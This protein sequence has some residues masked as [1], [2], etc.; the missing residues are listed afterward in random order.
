MSKQVSKG[1]LAVI[2]VIMVALL[3]SLGNSV[4]KF[5][6]NKIDGKFNLLISNEN[7]DLESVIK[8]YFNKKKIPVKITYA[9]TL[10]MMNKINSGEKYDAIW[11]SNSIW[12]YM[13]DN[14][15]VVK[16]SKSTSINPI[17]FGIKK[18]LAQKLNF[19]GRDVYTKDILDKIVAKELNFVM[20]SATRTNTGASAYLG[21][22]ATLAGNPEVLTIDN[23]KDENLKEDIVKFLSGVERTSGSEEF[24]DSLLLDGKYDA[25]VSYESS[26]I[27]LNKKLVGEGKEPFY[28]IYPVDG[29][30]ISDSPLAYI[31][32]GNNKKD[33]FD[34]FQNF[35]LSAEFQKELENS[36]R[37]VW[38]GGVSNNSDNSIFN[39]DWG[40]DTTKYIMP[41]KYPS[42]SVI[43]EA[44]ALYQSEFR[45]PT[46]IVF[47][48]DYSGSMY[49]DGNEQLIDAMKYILNFDTASLNMLQFSY[50]D[51]ISIIPFATNVLG[52][53]TTNDGTIVSELLE[54]IETTDTMG[55]TNIYGSLKKALSILNDEDTSNY[56]LSIV[57]M[58]DG[59]GNIDTFN[60]FKNYYNS[61]NKDIPIYGILFGDADASQLNEISNYTGGKVFDGRTNLLEAFKEV[62][63][64][65]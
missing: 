64:Y 12:L 1:L 43:K 7:V 18:S 50:K 29:V 11:A 58:T 60:S 19:I 9:G 57:L 40:I 28:L 5:I 36:G 15:S 30:T 45:K 47:C 39:K 17:V 6:E 22:L 55:S 32:N 65:N 53:Y 61:V 25:V 46:H 59:M 13:L 4:S 56:N 21:F 20:N 34:D 41:I 3:S 23:L 14:S 52:T 63:G 38:Y 27:S 54:K 26:L 2:L 8:D 49:G 35:V 10:E 48:L 16:S 51:K 33:V 37:R 44:L 31:D 62:R 24:L 42:V